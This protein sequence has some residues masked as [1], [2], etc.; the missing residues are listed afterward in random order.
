MRKLLLGVVLLLV[1][2]ACDGQ[3]LWEKTWGGPYDDGCEVR[4]TRDGGM[5]AMGSFGPD[6]WI[7][8]LDY[9]GDTLWTRRISQPLDLCA[10]TETLD[11]GFLATG[12]TRTQHRDF[13]AWKFDLRGDSTWMRIYID[14]LNNEGNYTVLLRPDSSYLLTG[15]TS[16][17]GYDMLA[18]HIDSLGN[19]LWR[20]NYGGPGFEGGTMSAATADGGYILTTTGGSPFFPNIWVVK[21]DALGDTLWTHNY[22]E[23]YPTGGSVPMVTAQGNILIMGWIER[24]DY[25]NYL[26]CLDSAGNQLWSQVYPGI[27]FES[28]S[29]RGVIEDRFGGYTFAS[30]VD[31][32]YGPV[33]SD[34]DIALFRLD[35]LGNAVKIYRLGHAGSEMPRYFEQTNDGDY[36]LFGFSSSFIPNGQQTYLARLRPDGCGPFFYDLDGPNRRLVCP[37]DTLLLDAGAGFAQYLWSDGDTTQMRSVPQSDTLYVQATDSQGCI[38]HSSCVIVTEAEGPQFNWSTSGN[39]LV[40]F[41]GLPGDGTAWTW[42]F[43]DGTTANALDTMHAY[44]QA[45]TYWVCF[46]SQ[47]PTCGW[48]SDCDSVTVS[49]TIAAMPALDF[50]PLISPNPSN[51]HLQITNPSHEQLQFNISDLNGRQIYRGKID[52]ESSEGIDASSWPQGVYLLQMTGEAQVHAHM[53]LVIA[54]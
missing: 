39:L 16:A 6:S 22:V 52:A 45:G 38:Y 13:V 28:R 44:A 33:G 18:M 15:Y 27:G 40:Q 49:T 37:N 19:P 35:S 9:N 54:K 5:I 23:P 43:G 25:D 41:Q 53:R 7:M 20:K 30:S 48:A 42:D 29:A 51:G 24:A 47:I 46:Q 2:L 21:I 26:L 1:A 12:V 34:H 10:I 8:R 4:N 14:T 50:R 31:L 36:L 3:V 32:S 11:G 17:N